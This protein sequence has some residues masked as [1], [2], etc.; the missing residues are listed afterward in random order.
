MYGLKVSSI[1]TRTSADG[2]EP[3][4]EN[5]HRRDGAARLTDTHTHARV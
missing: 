1:E 4:V 2:G 5:R 3:A